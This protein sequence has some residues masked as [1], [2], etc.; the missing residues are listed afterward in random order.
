MH[1][2]SY[3]EAFLSVYGWMMYNTLYDLLGM[4]WLVFLPFMKLGITT[5]IDTIADS[6]NSY[7]QF[8]KGLITF[9]LM[10]AALVLAL[11]PLDRITMKNTTV[12][13]VCTN[14]QVDT[15]N[16]ALKD[17]YRFDVAE[18]GKVP[19]LPSLVMRIGA[20]FNNVI[21]KSIPCTT[22]VN[23]FATAMQMSEVTDKDLAGEMQRFNTECAIPARNRM[24]DLMYKAPKTY[25][26][27]LEQYKKKDNYSDDKETNYF[28]SSFYKAMMKPDMND[29]SG[30]I[31]EEEK[32]IVEELIQSGTAQG[33]PIYSASPVTEVK[34]DNPDNSQ[35]QQADGKG[36][37]SCIDWWDNKLL[38][39]LKESISKDLTYRIASGKD[40]L[41]QECLPDL[42]SSTVAMTWGRTPNMKL[43]DEDACIA[44]AEKKYGE[45]LKDDLVYHAL[46]K[47]NQGSLM[48]REDK[49]HAQTIGVL[50]IV[51]AIISTFLGGNTSVLSSIA[52]SAASFYTQMFFYRVMMQILQPM[53]LMGIFCFW[54]IYLVVADYRWQTILKGLIM[55]LIITLMP[56]L[57]AITQHLDGALWNALYPDVVKLGTAVKQQ[58]ES[59]VERI[60]LDAAST[61]FNVI[62]PM[63]LMYIVAEAGGGHPGQAI[64]AGHGY[65]ENVGR[66]GSQIT[67]N[68]AISGTGR[69][70]DRGIDR[71]REWRENRTRMRNANKGLPPGGSRF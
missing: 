16:Q 31:D 3:L 50:G 8:K 20:G 5:F 1:V 28:N 24:N 2:S 19:L 26:K 63:L 13:A 33:D 30:A 27:L 4:T 43:V 29:I 67:T 41:A 45:E 46:Q 22:D 34:S 57:W 49:E 59:Y 23:R 38:A 70:V 18:G 32:Q 14:L 66:T 12:N 11:V 42:A 52:N 55:I 15:N 58:G 69:G 44:A 9:L 17:N 56:G 7:A 65:A 48:N 39:S 40:Q 47:S 53:L 51:G 64:Q 62:F 37:V 6:G 61:V 60:L 21:Y 25:K 36:P 54:G 71:V 10:V 68:A 35:K